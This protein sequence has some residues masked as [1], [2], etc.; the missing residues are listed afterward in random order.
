MPL[1]VRPVALASSAAY[2]Q[3]SLRLSGVACQLTYPD[4]GGT[5]PCG[6]SIPSGGLCRSFSLSCA[7]TLGASAASA[8]AP[9]PYRIHYF[10]DDNQPDH[11]LIPGGDHKQLRYGAVF[12]DPVFID[13]KYR[14][15]IK[16]LRKVKVTEATP[17]KAAPYQVLCTAEITPDVHCEETT[18]RQFYPIP[19]PQ[20]YLASMTVAAITLTIRTT[21]DVR[22]TRVRLMHADLHARRPDGSFVGHTGT[23]RNVRCAS[24]QLCRVTL[25]NVILDYTA[26]NVRDPETGQ[27]AADYP[28]HKILGWEHVDI[29]GA[30]QARRQKA[31]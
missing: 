30:P 3:S 8:A 18:D 23:D 16:A 29:Q 27:T 25:R 17:V 28:V 2:G 22:L 5:Q 12:P 24:Q 9:P 11:A 19:L 13:G 15:G 1:H 20:P 7:A 6:P 10:Y 31:R 4:L 26:H 21:P 14:A